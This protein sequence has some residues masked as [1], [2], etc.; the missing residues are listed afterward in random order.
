ISA[1]ADAAVR[2][3]KGNDSFSLTGSFIHDQIGFGHGSGTPA[4]ELAGATNAA[5]SGNAIR[6]YYQGVTNGISSGRYSDG[7]TLERNSITSTW[8]R[9]IDLTGDAMAIRDNTIFN[10]VVG[11]TSDEPAVTISGTTA[12]P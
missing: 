3:G 8:L 7:L 5:V 2:V 11:F 6:S 10:N 9:A 12:D 4:I 1:T